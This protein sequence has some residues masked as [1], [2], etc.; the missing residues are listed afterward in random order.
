MTMGITLNTDVL[1]D[2]TMMPQEY[3]VQIDVLVDCTMMPQEYKVQ[4]Y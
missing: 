2:C 3:K 4:I 1:V